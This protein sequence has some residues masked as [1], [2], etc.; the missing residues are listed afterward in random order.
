M[1]SVEASSVRAGTGMRQGRRHEARG[2]RHPRLGRRPREGV[3]RKP[4]LAARR[5]R[6]RRRRLPH[7]P[8]HAARL[9]VLDPVRQEP[10]AGRARFGPEPVPDRLR[11]RGCARRAGRRA[12][13]RSSE[14]FHEGTRG[15]RFH[16]DGARRPPAVARSQQLRLVRDVQRSGRQ[17]LA[18]PGESR[19]GCPAGSTRPRPRSAPRAIWRR[20]S[21]ARRRRTAS[22]RSG[23]ARQTRTGPTGT[24]STWCGSR[25][26]KSCRHEQRL[27]RHRHRRRLA[28]RAL[29]RRA[30]RGRPSRRPRR[31]RARRR[32][33]LLLGV[34]PV[35]DAA[36]PGRGGARR[37][38]R[39]GD[40]RGRRRGGARLARLH[41]LELLRR[42][43][44]ALARG[45]RHRPAARQ[46][47]ARRNGCGRG[48]RRAPHR[49]ARRPRQR[50]RPVR[51]AGSRAA[52]ARGHLDE[53]RGDRHEGG[54]APAARARRRAGRRRDGAGR[55]PLRRRGGDRRGR[56]Q[57]ATAR[58]CAARARRWA[59]SC[60]ATASS[61]PSAC[62]RPKRDARATS[63]S[64]SSTTATS[65]A[66]TACSSPPAGGRAST[67]SAWRRS[68]WRPTHAESRSTR[69]LRAAERLW[70]VGDVTGI[71]QLTHVGKYQGEVVAA[72]ILGE[73]REANYDAVPRVVYTDPEAASV[74]AAEARVQRDRA[75]VGDREDRDVHACLRREQ[76]V[77]DPAQRRRAADRRLCARPRG[78]RVAAAGD[79]GDP[80]ARSARRAA[81]HHPALPHVLGDLRRR[82]A[83]PP[84]GD[85][86]DAGTWPFGRLSSTLRPLLRLVRG[87]TTNGRHAQHRLRQLHVQPRRGPVRLRPVG[88]GRGRRRHG[89]RGTVQ[90]RGVHEE[91][92]RPG[93]VRRRRVELRLRH[94][95]GRLRMD[96]GVVEAELLAQG[97]VDRRH[98]S[99][100]PGR[101]RARVLPRAHHRGDHPRPRCELQGCRPPDPEVRSG[102]HA[103]RQGE[104]KGDRA[105]DAG[106]EAV[107]CVELPVRA[108]RAARRQGHQHRL[109][110]REAARRRRRHRLG[111][112]RA[113]RDRA[114]SSFRTSGSRSRR[115]TRG[116]GATGRRTSSSRATTTTRTRSAARSSS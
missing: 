78:G 20:R 77:P 106:A 73:P 18:A 37:A 30:R 105:E 26:A 94:D 101:E 75:A 45:Q 89:R 83:R 4:R 71:W 76:R 54:P 11:H 22:T 97:R 111:P 51:A 16:E 10:H 60:A 27:R 102:V 40:R 96:R 115:T 79:A 81:R 69:S 95:A 49:R 29:R 39:D 31:A 70:A 58:A 90:V 80:R 44:G 92:H 32:R 5:R 2:G 23:P 84:P 67:G 50:G 13:S 36:A 46:R 65:S 87:E 108:R 74:G 42:G 64:S 57:R 43:T 109:V 66:A 56:R 6:R 1:S 82:A 53:P 24:P 9:R 99:E 55:S 17:R 62:T 91:A 12:V 72:N 59:R 21:A 8:V 114:G 61:S 107:R 35:E 103:R 19:R 3:L 25:P 15:A 38:R 104:R 100:P 41:G 47:P 7:R 112:R 88:R 68:A 86:G 110:H 34:H 52:R 116:R 93:E 113:R 48:R 28:G 14:V 85:R 33:V 98:R 63:T